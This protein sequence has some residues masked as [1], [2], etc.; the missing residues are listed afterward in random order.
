[1]EVTGCSHCRAFLVGRHQDKVLPQ[2]LRTHT[3]R[4]LQAVLPETKLAVLVD[5]SVGDGGEGREDVDRGAVHR[6]LPPGRPEQ[7]AGPGPEQGQQ[8]GE[9][10]EAVEETQQDHQED[11]L[12]EGDDDVA[13]V[14]DEWEDTQNGC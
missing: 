7:P 4:S 12:G 3:D 14:A 2:D 10:E 8:D 1:M 6:L 13:R 5:E 9:E 11:H